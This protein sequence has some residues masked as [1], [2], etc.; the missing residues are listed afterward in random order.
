MQMNMEKL[1]AGLFDFQRFEKEPALQSVIDEVEAR[2]FCAELT[3]DEL[4]TLSA[5]GDPFS[6]PPDPKERDRKT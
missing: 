2:Y 1:L 6:Q 3:D 5:A 4:D